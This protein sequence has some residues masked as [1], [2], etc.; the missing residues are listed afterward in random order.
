MAWRNPRFD[1]ISLGRLSGAS[2]SAGTAFEAANPIA[3]ISDA[4]AQTVG[5]FN[6]SASDQYVQLDRGAG[7]DS[8]KSAG[9]LFIPEG[10]NLDGEDIRVEGD[11]EPTFTAPQALIATATTISGTGPI[12]LQFDAGIKYADRYIR[13][14][15][16]GSQQPTLPQVVIGNLVELTRGPEPDFVEEPRPTALV[17]ETFSGAR[18]ALS[19]GNA[20][21][22]F[23]YTFRRVLDTTDLTVLEWLADHTF[24]EPVVVDPAYDD[25]TPRWMHV[26]DI[27]RRNDH[28]NP[29]GVS[30]KRR[31]YDVTFEEHLA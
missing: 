31:R 5:T 18:A 11:D 15:F 29:A 19:R 10:H 8:D 16:E 1:L 12:H 6:A 9:S 21:R 20:R 17:Y 13:V 30:G 7:W 22:R 25:E 3:H 24:E 27:G 28:P 26:V 14:T 23:R 4:R 2:W